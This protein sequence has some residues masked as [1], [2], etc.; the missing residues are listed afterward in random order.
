MQTVYATHLDLPADPAGGENSAVSRVL[1][2]WVRRRFGVA[3]PVEGDGR[4]QRDGTSVSWSRLTS[5]GNRV[6]GLWID[7]PHHGGSGWRWRTYA[8]LGREGER[9][10]LRV[11]VGLYGTR[12]TTI[13]LPQVTVGRP[14]VVRDVVDRF[15]LSADG[16]PL[17]GVQEITADTAPDLVGLIEDSDRRLPVVVISTDA[18]GQ[19]FVD[20][21]LAADRMLGLAHVAVVDDH[22][23]S[24]LTTAFTRNLGCFGGAIRV[25]WPGFS[26]RDDRFR[27]R[28]YV[29]GALDFHGP[30]GLVQ[31]IT[32]TLG[33]IAGLSID[34]P[35]LRRELVLAHRE[36]DIERRVDARAASAAR[37]AQ[38]AESRLQVEAADFAAFAEEY[39]SMDEQLKTIEQ[40]AL[41][42]EHEIDRVR[43]ERDALRTQVAE[44]VRAATHESIPIPGELEPPTTVLEAVKRA[45]AESEQTQFVPSAFASAAASEY[46]DPSRV[47]DDLRL[48]EQVAREWAA[49]ELSTGPS[50]ALAQR[51]GAFRRGI[52]KTAVNSYGSDYEITW[53]GE[54]VL[55]GPHLRRGV[56]AVTAILRIYL[57]FDTD[58][59]TIVV[60][61]VGRKLRDVSNRN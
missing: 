3:I 47:L 25:Y 9:S 61:H 18:E 17:G 13:A 49:G 29:G 20:P 27:H 33:R 26:R 48:L 45:A 21:L 59:C 39:E 57:Y 14:G 30:S 19:S 28:L 2:D 50:D 7:Q 54:T 5:D 38:A 60:G 36:R 1:R 42:L 41:E 16:L 35:P 4:A 22:A 32:A 23:A 8:D 40:D 56:G 51:S 12:H 37:I 24:R 44:L 52:S 11:R 55:M 6:F 43:D 34:E 58:E 53:R 31:E 15:E 10:W 46:G